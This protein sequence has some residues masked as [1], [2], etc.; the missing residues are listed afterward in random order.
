MEYS[1]AYEL[2]AEIKASA[3]YKRFT[4][5]KANIA[6]GSAAEALIAEYRRLQLIAQ[7]DM[8]AGEQNGENL[9]KL[10]RMGELLHM[11]PAAS[12]YLIAEFSL[13]RALGDIYRILAEA[14]GMDLGALSE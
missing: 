12:E 11:D 5:A 1:K 13:S 7:A 6:P 10:R 9:E 2:A 3:E 4:E 14:A 8:V